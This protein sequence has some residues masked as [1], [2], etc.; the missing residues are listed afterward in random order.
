MKWKLRGI[1]LLLLCI[2]LTTVIVKHLQDKKAEH[3]ETESWDQTKNVAETSIPYELEMSDTQRES[4]R[5]EILQIAGSYKDIY[6][7]GRKK[8]EDG[9]NL[10]EAYVERIIDKIA[11]TGHTVGDKRNHVNLRNADNIEK[12]FEKAKQSSEK[13]ETISIYQV[14]ENG[15]MGRIDFSMESG[16][17]T[18]VCATVDWNEEL[19]PYVTYV[20]KY[21][22]TSWKYTEKGYFLYDLMLNE[23]TMPD[24]HDAIRVKPL[25]DDCRE[26]SEKYIL[27]MGYM[28]NNVFLTDWDS[29]S[30]EQVN[31][32]DAFDFL[33]ILYNGYDSWNVYDPSGI[34]KKDYEQILKKYFEIDTEKLEKAAHYNA[35]EGTYPWNPLGCGSYFPHDVPEPEVTAYKKHEDG[36]IT[37]TVD[38]VWPECETDRAFTHEVRI[39]IQEDG[40]AKYLSNRIVPSEHNL[41]PPYTART[42]GS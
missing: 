31:F 8:V 38:A 37:L 15:N 36:T 9:N 34:P 12:F 30:I 7:E 33:C 32:N 5:K 4:V 3:E 18:A 11:E 20:A 39:K 42:S 16:N 14:I 29:S 13:P 25:P 1:L 2:I 19:K 35:E 23:G 10:T 17:M 27:P 41:L 21:G 6:R 22:V 28:A 26:F 24:G 40:S